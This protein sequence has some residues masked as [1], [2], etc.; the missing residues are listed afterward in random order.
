MLLP[1][2]IIRVIKL[3]AME[4]GNDHE[5]EAIGTEEDVVNAK[6]R[7]ITRVKTQ[8]SREKIT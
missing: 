7:R 4:V 2:K 8:E 3:L 6:P 1:M 5:A